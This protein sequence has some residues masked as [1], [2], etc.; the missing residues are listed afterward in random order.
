M[1]AILFAKDGSFKTVENVT[2]DTYLDTP[3]YVPSP[4]IEGWCDGTSLS[5]SNLRPLYEGRGMYRKQLES[6]DYAV[7]VEE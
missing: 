1:N 2:Y 3:I 7:F 5:P 4:D 6:A